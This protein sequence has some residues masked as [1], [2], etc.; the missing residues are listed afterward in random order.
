M[1]YYLLSKYDLRDLADDCPR[2]QVWPSLQCHIIQN[3]EVF[4]QETTSGCF[5][6]KMTTCS[7]CFRLSEHHGI[8]A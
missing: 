7:K 5:I 2:F 1:E 8:V 3:M 4:S 6:Q